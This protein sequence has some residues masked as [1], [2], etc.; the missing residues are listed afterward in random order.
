[1]QQKLICRH[2]DWELYELAFETSMDIFARTQ[3]FPG[4]E[5]GT[6]TDPLRLASRSLCA[7]LAHAWRTRFDDRL[8]RLKLNEAETLAAEIQTW[9]E[10]AQ[11]CGYLEAATTKLLIQRYRK[12]LGKVVWLMPVAPTIDR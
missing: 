2:S 1:M 10:F 11:R 3:A 6:L 5:K 12:I 7:T 4:E 8:F 9:L